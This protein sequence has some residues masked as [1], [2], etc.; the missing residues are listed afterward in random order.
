[1]DN[2]NCH[3]ANHVLASILQDLSFLKDNSFIEQKTYNDVVALLPSRIQPQPQQPQQPQQPLSERPPLPTRK[4]INASTPTLPISQ[5]RDLPK[6][7]TRRTP[8]W[9]NGQSQ[10]MNKTIHSEPEKTASPPPPPPAYAQAVQQDTILTT[11]EALYDYHGEDPSTDLS[12]KQGDIIEV[13]EYVNDDWWKGT[14]HG[15]SGIF[16]QN[17]VKKIAPV[18]K[19]KRPWVPPVSAKPAYSPPVNTQPHYSSDTHNTPYSYPPPPQ[20]MYQPP[21]APQTMYPP[22]PP[23]SVQSYGQP[24]PPP[25]VQSYSQPPAVVANGHVE[26]E[27]GGDNKVANMAKKFGGNVATAATWGFGA[28]LGSQAASAIF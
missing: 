3:I 24:P 17:H 25:P 8:D 5:P 14:V 2:T 16:P 18:V 21:P 19:A 7:P 9:Q 13:I 15:K 28:T 12:F 10:Q 11:A 1:M 4:S 26:E 27:H 20:A 22:P 6:L 23:A